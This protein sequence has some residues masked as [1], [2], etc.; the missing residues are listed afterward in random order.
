MTDGSKCTPDSSKGLANLFNQAKQLI[1]WDNV[2]QIIQSFADDREFQTLKA[3]IES[4]D[5]KEKV[6]AIRNSEE[7]KR[8]NTYVCQVLHIDLS[9]DGHYVSRNILRRYYDTGIR[10]LISRVQS[11]IPHQ[12][13]YDLYLRLIATDDQLFEEVARMRSKTFKRIVKRFRNY[14]PEYR[15]LTATLWHLGVPMDQLKG[16]ISHA[17]GWNMDWDTLP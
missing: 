15:E 6:E 16:V 1:P 8:F 5:Y 9:Q 4:P 10:G 12:K 3:Y 7:Y 14:V 11:V 17:L 13:L 2:T